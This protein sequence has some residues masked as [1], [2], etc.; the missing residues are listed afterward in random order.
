MVIDVDTD[1]DIDTDKIDA[2]KIVRIDRKGR[3]YKI[4]RGDKIVTSHGTIL[5]D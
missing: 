2:D 1:I 3:T 4:D 5:A